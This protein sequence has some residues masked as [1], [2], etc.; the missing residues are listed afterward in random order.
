MGLLVQ[1]AV[2]ELVG[3]GV[4]EEEGEVPHP[5]L[6]VEVPRP[7]L[8]GEGEVP[9]ARPS[10]EG[11]AVVPHPSLEAGEEGRGLP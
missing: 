9:Q 1:G 2:G 10:L 6:E 11:A 8:V 4:G 3:R 5:S 7:S